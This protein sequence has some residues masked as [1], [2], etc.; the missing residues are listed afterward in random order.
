MEN[1]VSDTEEGMPMDDQ[2]KL[3]VLRRLMIALV[4]FSFVGLPVMINLWP[5]GWL[6]EPSQP[7]YEGMIGAIYAGFALVLLWAARDPIRHIVIVYAYIVSS[8]FHGSF[9]AYLALSQEG[10]IVH[11]YGDILFNFAIAVLFFLFIPWGMLEA[12]DKTFLGFTLKS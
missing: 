2:T 3:R 12:K 8:I 6:W 7:D 4:I 1:R 9:M 11:L 5:A 10:E